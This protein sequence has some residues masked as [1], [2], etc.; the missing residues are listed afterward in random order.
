[1]RLPKEEMF[2]DFSKLVHFMPWIGTNYYQ[3]ELFERKILLLGESHYS[4]VFHDKLRDETSLYTRHIMQKYAIDETA[5]YYTVTRKLLVAAANA[6]QNQKKLNNISKYDFWHSVAFYNF[7]QVFV[8]KKARQRPS[9]QHWIEAHSPF[10]EILERLMPDIC[11]ALGKELWRHLPQANE[12]I[13]DC[14]SGLEFKQYNVKGKKILCTFSAHPSSLMSYKK[15]V[16]QVARCFQ[17]T[18][19]FTS[20]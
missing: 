1:M 19:D 3:N 16:P 9:E 11:V 8:G 10:N 6:S 12:N 15:F 5:R 14:D 20:A 4:T 17:M 18:S 13:R 7:V 2:S